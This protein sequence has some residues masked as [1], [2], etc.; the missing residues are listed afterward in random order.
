MFNYFVLAMTVSRQAGVSQQILKVVDRRFKS[1]FNL[2]KKAKHSEYRFQD[3]KKPKYLKKNSYY[4]YFFNKCTQY[5]K[6]ILSFSYI[7]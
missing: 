3:I 6:R 1:F 7:K 4:I 2:I 5:Q